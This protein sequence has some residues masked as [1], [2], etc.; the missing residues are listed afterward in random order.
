MWKG[1]VEGQAK[2][3]RW[4]GEVELVVD[5]VKCSGFIKWK[6]DR[7]HCGTEDFTGSI[8]GE[9][10]TLNSTGTK[11]DKD[12]DC[13]PL[14]PSDYRGTFTKQGW[15]RFDWYPKS[16]SAQRGAASGTLEQVE[17]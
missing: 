1:T 6:S 3:T 10:L 14:A 4:T 2:K 7:G 11:R 16:D 5:G 17:R 13:K 15:I 12:K 9:S 8:H